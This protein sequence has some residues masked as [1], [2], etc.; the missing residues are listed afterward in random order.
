MTD[1]LAYIDNYLSTYNNFK[2]FKEQLESFYMNKQLFNYIRENLIKRETSRYYTN[3][4][5][6]PNKEACTKKS[7]FCALKKNT[8]FNTDNNVI[9]RSDYILSNLKANYFDINLGKELYTSNFARKYTDNSFYDSLYRKKLFPTSTSITFKDGKSKEMSTSVAINSDHKEG[10]YLKNNNESYCNSL[11]THSNIPNSS[12]V[13]YHNMIEKEILIMRAGHVCNFKE[14]YMRK[15]S[16]RIKHRN[17]FFNR[18]NK[19]LNCHLGLTLTN[20][21][22]R[23]IYKVNLT[24][25]MSTEMLVKTQELRNSLQYQ[26]KSCSFAAKRRYR[27]EDKVD[28]Q[29]D[30]L[31]LNLTRKTA[32]IRL[33]SIESNNNSSKKSQHSE[34]DYSSDMDDL[35]IKDIKMEYRILMDK[36]FLQTNQKKR[37]KFLV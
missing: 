18:S 5:Q 26:E 35:P 7:P 21:L 31:Y 2:E 25:K 32:F 3:I 1:F 33:R 24:A 34:S 11:N 4:K 9:L 8:M 13:A 27:S 12:T 19:T 30:D 10:P 36:A 22:L 28:K 20:Y 23:S 29:S 15:K 37:H 14:D 16:K 17:T 6:Q